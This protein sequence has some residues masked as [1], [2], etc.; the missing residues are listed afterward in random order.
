MPSGISKHFV[1]V[2][3]AANQQRTPKDYPSPAK[4][5]PK[6][7]TTVLKYLRKAVGEHPLLPKE[8]MFAQDLEHILETIGINSEAA[9]QC[10]DTLIYNNSYF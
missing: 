4:T 5:F 9:M 2:S 3:I 7:G 10:N 6:L 1:H 8:P